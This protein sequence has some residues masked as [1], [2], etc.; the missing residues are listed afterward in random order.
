MSNSGRTEV[1]EVVFKYGKGKDGKFMIWKT[2]GGKWQWDAMGN[3][4][5][6]LTRDEAIAEARE[7]IVNDY[8]KHNDPLK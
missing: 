7:W 6:A 3:C 2:K 8:D 5:E 1:T 4:G